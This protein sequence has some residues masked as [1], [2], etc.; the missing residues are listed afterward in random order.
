MSVITAPVGGSKTSV[1]MGQIV[2]GRAGDILD[3]ILG[4]CVGLALIHP[5]QKIAALAHVVL[6]SSSGRVAA[7]PGKFADTAIPEMLRLLASEGVPQA[8]LIAKLAGG[9]NM[10]GSNTTAM[11][12]GE[13]NIAAITEKLAALNIRIVAKHLGGAKGRRIALD[14]ES[15][16]M[17]VEIVGTPKAVL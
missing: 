7:T 2:V 4:S 1:G 9:A 8:G 14:C 15:G 17:Q 10:F 5:R 12:I 3:A 6:P 16:I 11:Q 13:G